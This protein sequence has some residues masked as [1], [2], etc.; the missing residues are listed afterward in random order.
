MSPKRNDLPLDSGP[1]IYLELN[2]DVKA[3]GVDPEEHYAA[4]GR[5]Y[6]RAESSSDTYN[7]DGLTSIHNHEF[8]DEPSFQKAYARWVQAADGQDYQW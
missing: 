8:M 5:A 7:F 4:Y 2:S 3:A 1:Q 6:A